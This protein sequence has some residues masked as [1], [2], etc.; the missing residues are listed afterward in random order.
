[1]TESASKTSS[2]RRFGRS[3][4]LAVVAAGLVLGLLIGELAIR[5]SGL[6]PGLR[7]IAVSDPNSVYQKSSNP[8]LGFEMKANYRASDPDSFLNY[9]RTNAH[10]QRDIERTIDKPQGTLRVIL[11]GDSVVEGF[12]LR[13]I[14]Q[15]LSR[16]MERR[17]AGRNWEVLNFGVSGYCTLAEVEL[18][19][20]KGLQF[21]P[22]VV[23][24]VFVQNDFENYNQDNAGV[25]QQEPPPW[26]VRQL[27]S[28]SHLVR[29]GFAKLGLLGS[30][31]AAPISNN[32]VV[33]GLQ[34]FAELA[35][36][37]QF[38]PVIAIWPQ[39]ADDQVLDLHPMPGN[40]GDLIIERLARMHGISS[41]RLSTVFR[42]HMRTSRAVSNPR[43]GYSVEG[44]GMHPNP[45]AVQLAADVLVGMVDRVWKESSEGHKPF[46]AESKVD[47]DAVR[48]AEMAS[49]ND[50]D[51]AQRYSNQANVYLRKGQ[52]EM[53][54][55]Y[56]ELALSLD[57]DSADVH[58]NYGKVLGELERRDEAREHF[59][60]AVELAPGHAYALTNF[61]LFLMEE[62]AFDE[63]ITHLQK[64]VEV[65]PHRADSH[66][67]LGRAV[68]S[69]VSSGDD[70]LGRAASHYEKALSI[71]PGLAAARYFLA[72]IRQSEGRQR[73]AIEEYRLV[74]QAL[75]E[76]V[77]AA[78]NLAWL[79]ATSG[80]TDLRDGQEAIRHAE[81]AARLTENKD[82][83]ILDTLAA[84]YAEGGR[85]PEAI[86]TV[87]K[88]IML[89]EGQG[90]ADLEGLRERLELYKG[91]TPYRES[92]LEGRTSRSNGGNQ[93]PGG[94]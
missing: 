34:E 44:D 60:R 38:Q 77:K 28:G 19:K 48:A 25:A 68:Q 11:L 64:A 45:D 31:A 2:R 57:P 42:D 70:S 17:L 35:K 92:S 26:L 16:Q 75:P 90:G 86:E 52:P 51:N 24:L 41:I 82:P 47:T 33:E 71:D 62:D 1:V 8:R 43:I 12:G 5:L 93:L 37:H 91:S 61:G 65:E 22:D 27:V 58:T 87:Q 78:N 15:T 85:F 54:V 29:Y 74:I 81:T 84:A 21:S 53:A 9:P 55:T 6:A 30:Q 94:R 13:E 4:R 72:V 39:F 7:P 80:D 50:P 32:N 40:D 36:E 3:T 56:Y 63:A 46:K 76:S 66:F 73:E 79:L 59:A 69:S 83:G 23:V 20:T 14:D 18:L 10:G 49:S 89:N 67:H 88:A